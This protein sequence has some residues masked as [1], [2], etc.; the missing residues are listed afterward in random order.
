[1][2]RPTR[3]CMVP[4]GA[5]FGWQAGQ[6]PDYY[7]DSLPPVVDIG[8]GSPAGVCFDMSKVPEKYQNAFYIND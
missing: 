5:E 3:V 6:E 4:S 7:P 1:M 2:A 8:P